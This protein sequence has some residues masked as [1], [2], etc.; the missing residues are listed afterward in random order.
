MGWSHNRWHVGGVVGRLL[1]KVDDSATALLA[2]DVIRALPN[3]APWFRVY[4]ESANVAA[5]IAE[6]FD[7]VAPPPADIPF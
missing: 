1:G 6:A 2:A 3:A 7:A 5:P 4:V